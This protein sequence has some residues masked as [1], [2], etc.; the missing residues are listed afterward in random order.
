MTLLTIASPEDCGLDPDRW[1][2]ALSLV[3]HWTDRDRSI[4]A[5][6]VMVGRNG[7]TPG[8]Q[9]YG[10]QRLDSDSPPLGHDAIFLIAS[11]TKPIV[12][13]GALL[14]V[15]RGQLSLNDRVTDFIPDFGRKGKYGTTIRNL[16]THTSGL[17]DMLPNNVELRK[18]KASL[19]TFVTETGAI[20]PDFPP[21]RSVQYQSMGIAVLAAIVEKITLSTCADFLR[22]EFFNPLGM[23][24]TRL[25]APNDW[26]EGPSPIVNRIA[27]IRVPADQ[28]EEVEWNWNSRYW[29][30]LGAPWG[31]LL[32]TPMDLGQFAQLMLNQGRAGD[33]PILSAATV[34]EATGNQ[35]AYMKDVPDEDRRF[36]P[37]GFGWRRQWPSHANSFGDLVSTETYGHWGAT[38]TVLWIDP[39]QQAF[40]IILTTQPLDSDG[41]ALQRLSNAISASFV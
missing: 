12:A 38:G 7:M 29:R 41:P 13:M 28:V 18:A 9:F 26:C 31:G 14:L 6:A 15:E 33:R 37:W 21:G 24:T 20:T 1:N 30:Q 2:S 10:R 3:R 34:R 27:Q 4:P 11:I 35:L 23:S 16:L 17:P 8:P 19:S 25:G 22:H 39:V 40:A 36:R 5:A 32:T